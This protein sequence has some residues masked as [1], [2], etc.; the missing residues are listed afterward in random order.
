MTASAPQGSQ[1]AHLGVAVDYAKHRWPVLLCCRTKDG[2]CD[3]GG[4]H[5]GAEV[6][7]APFGR[8]FKAG[9]NDATTNTARIDAAFRALPDA[10]VAISLEGGGLFFV[11][12]DSPEALAEAERLGVDGGARRESRNVGFVFARPADCPI[13]SITKSADG[14]DLEIRTTGYMLA[15][16]THANGAP[17]RFDP[18]AQLREAPA[19]AVERLKKKA[20]RLAAS[21]EA[22]EARRAE[23]AAAYGTGQEPPVRLHQRG[24]RRWRGELTEQRNGHLDRS[25][26]LF[27]IGLDLAECNATES[28]IVAALEERDAALGWNTYTDRKDADKRYGEIAERAVARAVE[29]EK[30]PQTKITP[31]APSDG[32]AEEVLAFAEATAAEN[33]RLLRVIQ[34]REDR[35][36]V[37]EDYVHT[38][39]DLLAN[40]E[41][42][43]TDKIVVLA[44]TREVHTR[45]SKG[46]E[47][48]PL[49][50]LADRCG[51]HK[52]T[53][54]KAVE[55]NSSDD[56][57][58]GA[59]FRK[60][61]TRKWVEDDSPEGGHWESTIAVIPWKER[62]R[63]TLAVA[64][65]YVPPRPNGKR[66][67]SPQAAEARWKRFEPCDVHQDANIALL[68]SCV[69]CDGVV[70]ETIVR[71]DALAALNHL[72]CDPD[73]GQPP[74]VSIGTKGHTLGD[75]D[76]APM[77]LLDYAAT[78]PQEAP[79]RCPAP[80]CKA[81][82]F[83]PHPDGS[84][85]CLKSGHDPRAYELIPMAA[86]GSE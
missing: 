67:G 26:S 66:G 25:D 39:D 28:A 79:K 1:S 49:G 72:T 77:S 73:S 13:V 41:M 86:G 74:T 38:I 16:G 62:P 18:S 7:K 70:G 34:E 21:A 48:V 78:R 68:G 44:T 58:D 50:R 57:G 12:P 52:N 82:E 5:T 84:W 35:L 30:A 71:P 54:S 80:G 2:V 46:K 19:W 31:K 65:A 53:I 8:F 14:T 9:V 10:N 43:A 17:I 11:D 3:C 75:S 33:A 45:I 36:A 22:I 20:E 63:D 56:A 64:A 60:R 47:D 37:L 55:R 76:S 81:L 4:G 15:W 6:G 83:K 42:S 61:L 51:M 29:L 69:V 27:F 23:R 40:P 24:L 59:P 85:R 32:S